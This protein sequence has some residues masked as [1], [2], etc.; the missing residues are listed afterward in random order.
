MYKERQIPVVRFFVTGHGTLGRL[1]IWSYMEVPWRNCRPHKNGYGI[2]VLGFRR[3]I[4]GMVFEVLGFPKT[5]GNSCTK[6]DKFR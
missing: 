5:R 4:F 1:Y 6:S 2:Q 3:T